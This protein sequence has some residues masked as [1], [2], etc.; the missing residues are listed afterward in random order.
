MHLVHKSGDG[1]LAVLGVMINEGAHNSDFDNVWNNLP[2]HAGDHKDVGVVMK[3]LE[4][5]PASKGYTTY[6][7][8]LTTPPCS[9]GVTWLL[10]NDP[11]EISKKQIDAFSKIIEANNRPVQ[12]LNGRSLEAAK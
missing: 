2:L 8:S 3:A 10:L 11:I 4:L 12:P 7:G 1:A 5:L 6:S 9:E